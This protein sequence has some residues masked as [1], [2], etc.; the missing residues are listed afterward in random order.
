MKG[1]LKD[2]V[3]DPAAESLLKAS[4]PSLNV[5]GSKIGVGEL[6]IGPGGGAG[7]CRGSG[8]GCVLSEAAILRHSSGRLFVTVWENVPFESDA[9]LGVQRI[10]F[11]VN[12]TMDDYQP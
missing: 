10:A 8:K 2:A 4:M 9:R 11:I 7:S 6:K 3:L 1:L 5:L 12:K